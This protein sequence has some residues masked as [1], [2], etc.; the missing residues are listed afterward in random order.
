MERY[1]E[2]SK[3]EA[4]IILN[5][6]TEY[7]GTG[8]YDR[9]DKEGVYVCRQCDAPLYLSTHK[10]SSGC[11]WPAFEDEI[12]DAVLRKPDP[13]GMRTEIICKRCNGHLGHVFLGEGITSKNTR[14]CVNSASMLFIPAFTEEGFAKAIFAGGCFWG[15]EHLLGELQGVI[16]TRVGYTGGNVANPSY[17]EVCSGLTGHKEA[18]EVI[19][20]DRKISYE[21]LLKFFMEIHNPFQENGQGPDIGPGYRSAIFYLT[22]GQKE[23]AENVKRIIARQG[24]P[25]TEIVPASFFYP[26]E[27]YHQLYYKKTGG[28]PYCHFRVKRFP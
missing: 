3:Q 8:E 11:G 17:E 27:E 28:E 19:F 7:P 13:D 6:G 14:H 4:E 9:F 22:E 26:A 20:D 24:N 18:V 2:L 15:V 25:V 16:S 12:E 10:F 21:E 1:R 23:I 5:K